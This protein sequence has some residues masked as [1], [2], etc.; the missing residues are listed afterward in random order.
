MS[1]AVFK[2]MEPRGNTQGEQSMDRRLTPG[3]QAGK[4]KCHKGQIN[5]ESLGE[6][7]GTKLTIT[8][9]LLDEIASNKRPP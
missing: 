4:L 9:P 5:A 8:L 3:R 7:K 6:G 1:V 2:K